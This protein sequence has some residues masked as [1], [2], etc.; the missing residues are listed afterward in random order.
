MPIRLLLVDD[1]AIMIDGLV[2]LLNGTEDLNVSAQ[3][4]NGAFALA[5]LKNQPFELMVSDFNLPDMDGALLIKQAKAIQPALRIVVL[6]M[7][8][9]PHVVRAVMTA[10]ADAY[11]LKKYAHDEL[12]HAIETVLKGRQY[13]SAEVSRAL[14]VREAEVAPENQISERELEVLELL[15]EE[16]T[17][18]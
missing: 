3:A 15:I 11:V 5:H 8:E 18:K 13:L 17:S 1:H 7:H 4:V 2:A 9:E 12:L 10:G 14:L 16:K 6:T